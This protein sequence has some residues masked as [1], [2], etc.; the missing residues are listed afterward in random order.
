M[1]IRH[2]AAATVLTALALTGCKAA[3]QAD[4]KPSHKATSAAPEPV[5]ETTGPEYTDLTSD[6]LIVTFKIKHKQCFGSAGCN[7]TVSPDITYIGLDSDAIDPD[8]T[9][10]I[11]YEISGDESGT[12]VETATLT[13]RTSLTLTPSMISTSSGAVKITGEV[14]DVTEAY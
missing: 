14:T 5:E 13:D 12:I 3:A 9:Y 8:K 1:K 6:D 10:E 7:L 4:S 11:T 2:L